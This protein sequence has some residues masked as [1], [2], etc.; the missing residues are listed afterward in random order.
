MLLNPST[1]YNYLHRP[2]AHPASLLYPSRL[3]YATS[4]LLQPSKPTGIDLYA[5][6]SSFVSYPPNCTTLCA[7]APLQE[8]LLQEQWGKPSDIVEHQFDHF[9]K[10]CS[11]NSGHNADKSSD[12]RSISLANGVVRWQ[13]RSTEPNWVRST[14]SKYILSAGWWEEEYLFALVCICTAIG[15]MLSAKVPVFG[16]SE[17]SQRRSDHYARL[18]DFKMFEEAS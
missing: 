18:D 2:T 13:R 17:A 11:G 6:I 15:L 16:S 14:K 5:V 9:R 7:W 1:D 10:P 4:S 8:P 12:F 3:L